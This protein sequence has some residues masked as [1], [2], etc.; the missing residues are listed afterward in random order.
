MERALTDVVG[1]SRFVVFADAGK[2]CFGRLLPPIMIAEL[3]EHVAGL[4]DRIDWNTQ[5]GFSRAFSMCHEFPTKRVQ[6]FQAADIIIELM[7]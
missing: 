1:G 6:V 4:A 5:D 2:A 7:T 3:A